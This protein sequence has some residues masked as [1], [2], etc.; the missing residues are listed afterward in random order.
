VDLEGLNTD[1]FLAKRE[2]LRHAEDL[3]R[4]AAPLMGMDHARAKHY[5]TRVVHYDL[6]RME[7]GGLDLFRRYLIRQGI[8]PHSSGFDLYTR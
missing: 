1:L 5:I 6:G 8:V 7:L 4:A 3:A 2:G